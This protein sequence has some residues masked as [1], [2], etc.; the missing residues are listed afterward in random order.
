MLPKYHLDTEHALPF[1]NSAG[2][3]VA[4]SSQ[5]CSTDSI[6]GSCKTCLDNYHSGFKTSLEHK[7]PDE[8]AVARCRV[9][10]SELKTARAAQRHQAS[11]ASVTTSTT[12]R[13]LLQVMSGL[14]APAGGGCVC[15]LAAECVPK[16]G[17]L[18]LAPMRLRR[19]G[20]RTE[21]ADGT[22]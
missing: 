14:A 16:R 9:W 18:Q 3:T 19:S 5:V 15:D 20:N 7:D 17:I 21:L 4:K 10:P 22:T 13:L 6:L 11:R 8:E 1:G 2:C 12:P